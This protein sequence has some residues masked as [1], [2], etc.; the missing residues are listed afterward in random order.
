MTWEEDHIIQFMDMDQMAIYKQ[1]FL[2]R[3]LEEG[4]SKKKLS[5]LL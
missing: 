4:I 2:A 3:L 1:K 5:I